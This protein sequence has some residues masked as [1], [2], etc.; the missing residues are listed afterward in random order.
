MNRDAERPFR[1]AIP[2][3]A[4]MTKTIDATKSS[5]SFWLATGRGSAGSSGDCRD[6]RAGPLRRDAP[7]LG[8]NEQIRHPG[9]VRRCARGKP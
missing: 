3:D 7:V 5:A 2:R 6:G 8:K 9:A 1:S 4:A